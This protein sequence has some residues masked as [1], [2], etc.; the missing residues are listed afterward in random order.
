MADKKISELVAA[1]TVGSS[2]STVVVQNATSKKL[3]IG[4]LFNNVPQAIGV[5]SEEVFSV[6][7]GTLTLKLVSI[8]TASGAAA[9]SLPNGQIT[10]QVQNKYIANAGTGTLTIT[11]VGQGFTSI[12]IPA[13]G[14]VNLVWVNNKWWISG[15]SNGVTYG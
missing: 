11:C 13:N 6:A 2:D 7:S 15:N 3:D 5:L 4:T 1:T 8:I 14:I 12:I 10:R 9:Y